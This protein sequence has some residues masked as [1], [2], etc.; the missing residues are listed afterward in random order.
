MSDLDKL[1]TL[2]QRMERLGDEMRADDALY[3]E[4]LADR[5]AKGLTGAEAERHYNEWMERH[6]RPDLK[7]SK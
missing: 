3:R 6:G 7:T 1:Q 2:R 5:Q 4:E